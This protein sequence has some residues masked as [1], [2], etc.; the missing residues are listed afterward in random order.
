MLLVQEASPWLAC[1]SRQDV[2]GRAGSSPTVTAFAPR[3]SP[4]SSCPEML[5]TFWGDRADDPTRFHPCSLG[6]PAGKVQP[7]LPPAQP[8]KPHWTGCSTTSWFSWFIPCSWSPVRKLL[9]SPFLSPLLCKSHGSIF[10]PH[11]A[12]KHNGVADPADKVLFL[13]WRQPSQEDA[14]S[15]AWL[16]FSFPP[17]AVTPLFRHHLPEQG[18]KCPLPRRF[19]DPLSYDTGS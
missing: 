13:C 17:C 16:L 8:G 12:C 15:H 9:S 14:P 1:S 6:S 18:G 11:H 19:C 7:P 10:L 2:Q 3:S 4:T 5:N